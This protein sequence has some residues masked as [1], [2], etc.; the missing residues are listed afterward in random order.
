MTIQLQ[1]SKQTPLSK[2]MYPVGTDGS[3]EQLVGNWVIVSDNEIASGNGENAP[4]PQTIE[5]HWS[6]I[7]IPDSKE[8]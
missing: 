7:L 3:R 6:V 5:Q 4:R 2:L 1:S 8:R